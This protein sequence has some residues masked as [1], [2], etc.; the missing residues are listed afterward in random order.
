VARRALYLKTANR[1]FAQRMLEKCPNVTLAEFLS[2]TGSEPVARDASLLGEK[3][4]EFNVVW[5]AQTAAP[6]TAAAK[7]SAPAAAS[8]VGKA[9]VQPGNAFDEMWNQEGAAA[10]GTP[11]TSSAACASA[12]GSPSP[13]APASASAAGSPSASDPAPRAR[14]AAA[15]EAPDEMSDE[16]AVY[17]AYHK[18][19]GEIAKALDHGLSVLAVADKILV[20]HLLRQIQRMTVR[21]LVRDDDT[22]TAAEAAG[23]A[24]QPGQRRD[25][26]SRVEASMDGGVSRV[27]AIGRRL[28]LLKT[29]EALVIRHLDLL[30]TV[31]QNMLTSEA[32]HLAEILYWRP[33]K[34]ILG[35]VDP[36]LEIPEII[37]K[38]FPIRVD[39]AA[40]AKD[41]VGRM[42]T[43]RERA[44]FKDFDAVNLYKNVSGLNAVEFRNAMR[45]I[46]VECADG[47]PARRIFG[48]IR[49][50]KGSQSSEVQIPDITFEDIGGYETVKGSIDEVIRL[51]SGEF[52]GAD[53]ATERIAQ[54]LVPR[55][56]LFHGPPGTGKT[57]FSKAI[58]NRLNAT[59]QIVNGPE[60]MSKFVGESEERVRH[61]FSVARKNAPAV[62]VFDEFDSIAFHRGGGDDGASRASNAVVAQLLTEMDGFRGDQQ[63]LIVGTSNRP[64]VIDPAFLRP[65]RLTPI[66]IPLPDPDARRRIVEIYLQRFAIPRGP[67]IDGCL[68]HLVE[69]SEG[70]N[71]DDLQSLFRDAKRRE[72]LHKDPVT[73]EMLLRIA[74]D[75]AEKKSHGGRVHL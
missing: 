63:V 41:S 49:L 74:G 18:E 20:E 46:T 3:I 73:P 6:K 39:V 15:D 30:T 36:A 27:Q 40:M 13:A 75:I 47:T 38:R 66:E 25:I 55:G 51:M 19:I 42:V 60:I 28:N 68:D 10:G 37:R 14:A 31:G 54:E 4:S 2:T 9:P 26:S 5:V 56:I 22:G 64:D 8:A 61:L 50:F 70:F 53:E 62:I 35:F 12:A 43:R 59:L 44:K 58:A 32:K 24:S 71:G 23:P 69:R 34:V 45:Y 7:A 11:G 57:L 17:H 52:D 1:D 65:S 72:L 48:S 67:E 21:P 33:D 29:N 16:Q